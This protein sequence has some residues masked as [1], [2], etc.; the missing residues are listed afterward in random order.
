MPHITNKNQLLDVLTT[1]T[2]EQWRVKTNDLIHAYTTLAPDIGYGTI[3]DFHLGINAAWNNIGKT[4]SGVAGHLI[5][6][7]KLKS[8]A[9][10]TNLNSFAD[11]NTATISN[12]LGLKGSILRTGSVALDKL[13]I[14]NVAKSRI[15]GTGSATSS[16]FTEIEVGTGLT[17]LGTTI[18]LATGAALVNII[19]GTIASEKLASNAALDNIAE[20][21]IQSIKLQSNAAFNNLSGHIAIPENIPDANNARGL[22]GSILNL[23]S[24]PLNRL[25]VLAATGKFILGGISNT[26]ESPTSIL[27]LPEDGHLSINASNSTIQVSLN[28]TLIATLATKAIPWEK[29]D[30]PTTDPWI[31]SIV[32]IDTRISGLSDYVIP[33]IKIQMP[34]PL[35]WETGVIAGTSLG[36]V[37]L[38]KLERTA[39]TAYLLGSNSGVTTITNAGLATQVQA[40]PVIELAPGVLAISAGVIGFAADAIINNITVN[41]LPLAKLIRTSISTVPY[42]LGSNVHTS[43]KQPV[44]ELA[45]GVLA[46]SATGVIGFANDAIINNIVVNTLPYAKIARVG[47]PAYILGSITASA[48]TLTTTPVRELA[49]T[50]GLAITTGTPATIGLSAQGVPIAKLNSGVTTGA[51]I[52]GGSA[53]AA[54]TALALGSRF[55]IT[56]NAIMIKRNIVTRNTS[57]VHGFTSI[58]M[59]NSDGY[60]D[61]HYYNNDDSP[62]PQ[63]LLVVVPRLINGRIVEFINHITYGYFGYMPR[64]DSSTASFGRDNINMTLHYIGAPSASKVVGGYRSSVES[65]DHAMAI[66]SEILNSYMSEELSLSDVH[67][68]GDTQTWGYGT[69]MIWPL[70]TSI[71]VTHGSKIAVKVKILGTGEHDGCK[72]VLYRTFTYLDKT[73]VVQCDDSGGSEYA[74]CQWIPTIVL[75]GVPTTRIVLLSIAQTITGTTTKTL[76]I[77]STTLTL[78]IP[79]GTPVSGFNISAGTTTGTT[80]YAAGQTITSIL[81]NTA[82]TAGII[83][84]NNTYTFSTAN[85]AINQVGISPFNLT[86]ATI[87]LTAAIPAGTP[88]TGA[89]LDSGTTTGTTAYIAGQTINNIQLNKATIGNITNSNYVTSVPD[90][91]I[92]LTS[93]SGSQGSNIINFTG[94]ATNIWPSGSSITGSGIPTDT[95]VTTPGVGAGTTQLTLSKNLSSVCS[96]AAVKANLIFD[97]S[98]GKLK[99]TTKGTIEYGYLAKANDTGQNGFTNAR[100]IAIT[101]RGNYGYVGLTYGS[102]EDQP[103]WSNIIGDLT[104]TYHIRMVQAGS[105]GR[106]YFNCPYNGNTRTSEGM[107][108]I[109]LEEIP[110]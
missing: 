63:R 60:P 47:L 68:T 73:T 34:N 54:V 53:S 23:D 7:T 56:S 75:T 98:T 10:L 28:S 20:R 76:K 1:D 32:P 17:I 16:V 22:S 62:G 52:L 33:W 64:L 29:I 80:A 40:N 18:I 81:L 86:I 79:A 6:N 90:N 70:R 55:E 71:T 46:I 102:I 108:S 5:D 37:P 31:V 99:L 69:D 110:A 49:L 84:V 107:S 89:G 38:N 74:S 100:A 94:V 88:I 87:T 24:I 50:D 48:S 12:S 30:Y 4:Y 21:S 103:D 82:I 14:V 42:I 25:D 41:T 109:T 66:T 44:I 101:D 27:K 11:A 97:S 96:S 43:I 106:F 59:G 57:D 19:P 13:T 78:P 39:T 3:T 36:I 105:Y 72:F 85:T 61:T 104:F 45:P 26:G 58:E 83:A 65:V 67:L 35:P 8:D 92:T 77:K 9:S 2:F 95:T 93:P 51:F 15:L 91:P